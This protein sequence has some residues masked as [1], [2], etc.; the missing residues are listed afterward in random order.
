MN[1]D[2]IA[3]IGEKAGEVWRVLDSD[4]PQTLVQLKKKLGA[5]PGQME[6]ALGWL[7]REDKI[8]FE[9]EKKTYRVAL[10]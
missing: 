7:A 6:Y 8:A 2:L 1:S 10:K 4:G 3:E 9:S 5:K